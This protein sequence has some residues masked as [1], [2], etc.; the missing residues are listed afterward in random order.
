M[1][2]DVM[3]APPIERLPDSS[4]EPVC[5]DLVAQYPIHR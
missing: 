3:G 4:S 5:P 2:L 1:P